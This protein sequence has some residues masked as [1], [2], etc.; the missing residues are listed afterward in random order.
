MATVRF[1]S[2]HKGQRIQTSTENE[3]LQIWRC[4]RANF[5]KGEVFDFD[6]ELKKRNIELIAILDDDL[7]TL[8]NSTLAAYLLLVHSKPRSVTLHKVC[9]QENYRRQGIATRLIR[10]QMGVL[11]KRGCSTVRLWVSATN[12]VALRLYFGLGFE[13]ESEVSDYYSRG[14]RGICMSLNL[15]DQDFEECRP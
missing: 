4:E 8:Q 13:K 14:R 3:L 1:I 11:M 6:A 10:S 5:P 7:S 15:L 9:V 12:E 2:L